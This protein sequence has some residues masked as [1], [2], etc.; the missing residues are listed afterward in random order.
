MTTVSAAIGKQGH[1]RMES[2]DKSVNAEYWSI[3]IMLYFE[4]HDMIIKIPW[5]ADDYILRARA[6]VR[7]PVRALE[8]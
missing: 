6:H 2:Q 1:K 4:P 8:Y 3:N 5:L 7:V